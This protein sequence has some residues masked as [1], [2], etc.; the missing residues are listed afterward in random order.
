[1]RNDLR[2]D[3]SPVVPLTQIQGERTDAV[4]QVKFD[5]SASWSAYGFGQHRSRQAAGVKAMIASA[6]AAPI[7]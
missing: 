1:V 3:N 2:K 7:A 4:A 5:S 6:W